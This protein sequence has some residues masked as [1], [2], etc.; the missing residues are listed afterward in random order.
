MATNSLSG[1]SKAAAR[2]SLR[3]GLER[4]FAEFVRHSN[5][6]N[7]ATAPRQV[8]LSGEQPDERNGHHGSQNHSKPKPTGEAFVA[9]PQLSHVMGEAVRGERFRV[10]VFFPLDAVTRSGICF[11]FAFQFDDF[12]RHALD[13]NCAM[14]PLR[15][16]KP[17]EFRNGYCRLS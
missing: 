16:S 14:P 2:R 9:P 17:R 15:Y 7:S 6:A 11:R 1:R 3:L 10:D 13:H 12:G 5:D 8:E 4:V